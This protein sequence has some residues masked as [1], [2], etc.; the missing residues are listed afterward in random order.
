MVLCP[1]WFM[2]ILGQL[3]WSRARLMASSASPRAHGAREQLS[4]TLADGRQE[5]AAELTGLSPGS[6]T[7]SSCNAMQEK[8]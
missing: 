3:T 4:P 5:A 8:R 6:H 7:A 2:A 1:F